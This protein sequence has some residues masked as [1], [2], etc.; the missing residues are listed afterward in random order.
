[1]AKMRSP[2]YPSLT[3]EEAL[4]R[5]R[6]IY[7]AEHT[8]PA[9]KEVVANALGYSTLNGTSLTV[10]GA[11][12]RY[13]LL[14]KAGTDGLKVSDDAVTALELDEGHPLRC[15]AFERLAFNPTLFAELKERFGDELPSDVN[16]KHYLIQQKGF[17]PKAA[18]DVIRVYRENLELVIDKEEVYDVGGSS[19]NKETPPMIEP[20]AHVFPSNPPAG[21]NL[22]N[23]Q[24]KKGVHEFSFPLSFQRDVKA[25]VT[26]YGDKLKRRDLEFLTKKIGDLLEGFEDE[27]PEPEL[28]AATWR[29]KDHDQPVTITGELGEHDG[30]RF[31]AAK[32]TS[33]GIPEDELEFGDAKA[34]EQYEQKSQQNSSAS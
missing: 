3:L 5:T 11:L 19:Q 33:T 2:N 10:L 9:P 7:D 29:N 1:M 20:K 31:Y 28:R 27:E 8:H 15:Q 32:E 30:K 22:T 16:L 17:L 6:K 13:G 26:I 34:K 14:E 24:A 21:A 4:K 23:N 18:E 12:T 25:T